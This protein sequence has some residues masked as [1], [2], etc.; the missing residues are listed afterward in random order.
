M[1]QPPPLSAVLKVVVETTI[2]FSSGTHE[3]PTPDDCPARV[4]DPGLPCP[5]VR[6]M[7]SGVLEYYVFELAGDVTAHEVYLHRV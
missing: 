5:L 1:D 2:A 7:L 6:R 4:R 3:V